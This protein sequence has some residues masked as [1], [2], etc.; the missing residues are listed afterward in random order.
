MSTPTEKGRCGQV[1]RAIHRRGPDY[2]PLLFFNQDKEQSDIVVVDVVRHFMG[3]AEDRSEWGF[4]WEKLDRTMGQPREPLLP[5]W[6]RL[7]SLEM[8]DPDDPERFAHV[9]GIMREYGE[10]YY[11]AS[12]VLTGFT[13][14]SFL[15]G[16]ANLLVDLVEERPEISLLA[17][18]VFG[19]EEEVIRRLPGRGFHGVAF[20]D[21]WGTQENLILSPEL[22]RR[23]FRER[24]RRQFTLAHELG[25]EVYF[26][27][28]GYVREL[29]PELIEIGVDMLN[30]SQPNLYDIAEL[31]RSFGG[32]VCFVCPVSYQTTAISGTVEQ[33][34]ADVASLVEHLGS[35]DGGLIGYV[36]EYSSIGM[37]Q[38]NYRACIRAFRELGRYRQ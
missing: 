24:Y 13:V 9:P 8:P 19:F 3:A 15:R 29:V 7:P 30:L 6:S 31:G 5:E 26:H 4:S 14:M 10:R 12:L 11:L 1:R 36:E 34:Y 2:V 18:R 20:Y 33:I 35:Y 21:D 38:E 22:W 32:R 17:D 23:H 28:C 27:S 37:S 25:L 16:F